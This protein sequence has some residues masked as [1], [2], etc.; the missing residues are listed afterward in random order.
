MRALTRTWAG[1]WAEA[2]ANRRGFW[3]QI[4]VMLVND[5][6][7]IVF[8]YLFFDRVGEVRGWDVDQLV[9][10]FAILTTSAGLVLGGLANVRRINALAADG[11]L[12]ALLTL[13]TA[14]LP[15]LLVRRIETANVGDLFF[16]VA[17]FAL[18]GDPTPARTIVFLFGVVCATAILI[19]FLVAVGSLGFFIGRNEGGELGFH[20]LLL[21][22]SYPVDVFGG[23]VK[24]LLYTVVPAGFVTS[25]PAQLV[26]DPDAGMAAAVAAVAAGVAMLGWATFRLGLR[27]YTSGSGWTAA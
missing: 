26:D 1:A 18:L 14:T 10:L 19:G 25:V 12:D 8:W 4:A 22:S 7:W 15:H 6:I 3:F 16:G 17:L 2:W 20:A 24:V 13:P 21:F 9:I 23:A 5:V 27:R 11:G